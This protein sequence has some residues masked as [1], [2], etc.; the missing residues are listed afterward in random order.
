M[1]GHDIITIEAQARE[2]KARSVVI[3][4]PPVSEDSAAGMP[5]INLEEGG[6]G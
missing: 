4:Q 3:R 1:F 6:P 5:P 2:A